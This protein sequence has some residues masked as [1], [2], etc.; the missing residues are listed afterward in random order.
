MITLSPGLQAVIMATIMASVL[1]QVTTRC[2]SGSMGS[3][4]VARDLGGERLAEARCAPGDGVLVRRS[5]RRHGECVEQG[6]RRREIGE[7]LRQVD[8]LY[9]LA[10][11]VVF[12]DDGLGDPGESL[13]GLGHGGEYGASPRRLPP[14]PE[15]P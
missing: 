14:P 6:G 10:V 12:A 4:A 15:P 5:V 9:S 11:R 1:P 3:P 13:R 2:C 7:P 8:G